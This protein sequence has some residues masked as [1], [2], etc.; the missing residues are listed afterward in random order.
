MPEPGGVRLGRRRGPKRIHVAVVPPSYPPGC[1]EGGAR[2]SS[3]EADGSAKAETW[4]LLIEF[5]DRA[6]AESAARVLAAEEGND[7]GVLNL[8]PFLW[9]IDESEA[10]KVLRRRVDSVSERVAV[11]EGSPCRLD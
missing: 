3:E 4:A 6:L 8:V 9:G 1:V 10:A 2:R 5:R 11:L 7:T